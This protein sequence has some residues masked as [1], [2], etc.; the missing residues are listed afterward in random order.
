LT[1]FWATPTKPLR[2][3][4]AQN[5]AF[6]RMFGEINRHGLIPVTL[7]GEKKK[8]PVWQGGCKSSWHER[9]RPTTTSPMPA[10]AAAI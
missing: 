5:P 4:D 7:L 3:I 6:K 2:F 10:G 1:V 9:S 8:L